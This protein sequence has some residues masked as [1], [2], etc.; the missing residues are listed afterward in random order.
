MTSWSCT[1]EKSVFALS[2][3]ATIVIAHIKCVVAPF[4]NEMITETINITQITRPN[5]VRIEKK[6]L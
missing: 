5:N 1:M 6:N 3:T 2:V 4:E